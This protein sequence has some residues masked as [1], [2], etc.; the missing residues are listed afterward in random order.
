MRVDHPST[1]ATC[2]GPCLDLDA[3]DVNDIFRCTIVFVEEVDGK[4]VGA[5]FAGEGASSGAGAGRLDGLPAGRICVVLDLIVAAERENFSFG[6][7][8]C[9]LAWRRRG[10]W[11]RR[12][13]R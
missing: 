9:N 5:V 1:G 11:R 13:W 4:F 8:D 6:L 3:V 2:A 7:A 10:R 12:R